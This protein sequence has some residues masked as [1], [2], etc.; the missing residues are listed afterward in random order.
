MAVVKIVK[1]LY[2]GWRVGDHVE[3]FGYQ[4]EKMVAEQ[5]CEVIKADE[6][7]LP[8]PDAILPTVEEAP[9]APKKKK[10]VR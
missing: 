3:V 1:N 5:G 8:K 7:I 10:K 6:P 4:L 2:P 9:V